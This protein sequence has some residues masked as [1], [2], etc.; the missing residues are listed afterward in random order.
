ML[1]T[2][3]PRRSAV[4]RV[5]AQGCYRFCAMLWP[6]AAPDRRLPQ[7]LRPA[8]MPGERNSIDRRLAVLAVLG[9]RTL[10]SR[11]SPDHVGERHAESACL[12]AAT[13]CS[14]QSRV[15]LMTDVLQMADCRKL[16]FGAN[17]AGRIKSGVF[18]LYRY[19][20]P[21]EFSERTVSSDRSQ[22]LFR[23]SRQ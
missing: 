6:R 10:E 11:R 23:K 7:S 8:G 2:L 14:A 18:Y 4:N 21:P 19:A 20:S 9:P 12:S 13:L 17:L 3:P 1:A 16:A 15:P 5:A 22:R